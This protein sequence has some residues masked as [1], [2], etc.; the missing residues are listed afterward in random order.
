MTSI[1]IGRIV[2]FRLND[3]QAEAITRRRN[4]AR[5]NLERMRAERPGF[6]AHIGNPVSAG[7]VVPMIVTAVWPDE[8]GPGEPGINGQIILDGCDSLWVTSV[9][10]G[11][12]SGEWSWPPRV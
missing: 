3:A 10:E 4:D 8:F 11:G 2:H 7:Q 1:S 5:A 9:R 6:Q 12:R